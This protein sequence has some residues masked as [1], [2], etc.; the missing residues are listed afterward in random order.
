MKIIQNTKCNQLCDDLVNRLDSIRHD[1]LD[2]SKIVIKT[3]NRVACLDKN[4]V[5][6]L[7][8]AGS[9]KKIV[10]ELIPLAVYVLAKYSCDT[11][12]KIKWKSGNQ[13]YDAISYNQGHRVRHGLLEKTTYLEVTTVQNQNDY[14]VREELICKGFSNGPYE[15]NRNKQTKIIE[16]LPIVNSGYDWIDNMVEILLERIKNKESKKYE[17][18][19][20]L[21]VSCTFP[22]LLSDLEWEY[23]IS[24]SKP[25]ICPTSFKSVFVF[26][27]FNERKFEIHRA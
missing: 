4:S 5:Y 15:I 18:N 1:G 14:L 6:R 23:F 8:R 19:T 17:N 22:T 26:E 24:K 20:V 2:F 3:V 21:I 10:E 13:N 7:K 11:Q 25:N 27:R 12:V 16:S 9:Y